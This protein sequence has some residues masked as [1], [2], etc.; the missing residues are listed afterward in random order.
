MKSFKC[1]FII[2]LLFSQSLFSCKTDDPIVVTPP[3]N[4][5][6]GTVTDNNGITYKTVK[7][8][9][10]WWMAEN[11]RSTKFRNGELIPNVTENAEWAQ[12]TTA[13]YCCY[14]NNETAN[15]S[16][17]GYLYNWVTAADSRNIAPEGWHVATDA[18]WQTLVTFLGGTYTAGGK[19]KEAGFAHWVSPNTGATNSSGFTAL[20]TGSRGGRNGEFGWMGLGNDYWSSSSKNPTEA[21]AFYVGND[22]AGCLRLNHKKT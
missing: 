2:S 1:L 19:M 10:Q 15:A 3:T 20:P 4:I 17:Y 6:T 18:D 5:E 12:L 14:N 11:L 7:I 16:T 21:W 8:G 22:M 13:A 9:N